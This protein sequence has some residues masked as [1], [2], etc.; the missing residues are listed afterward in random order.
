MARKCAQASMPGCPRVD[1]EIGRHAAVPREPR[2]ARPN[3][4]VATCL[5]KVLPPAPGE[6]GGCRFRDLT[7]QVAAFTT[8]ARLALADVTRRLPCCARSPLPFPPSSGPPGAWRCCCSLDV[9]RTVASL[10]TRAPAA[11]RRQVE[12][13]QRAGPSGRAGRTPP[14]A[15][16]GP[17]GGPEQA[18]RQLVGR[19][20][21]AARPVLAGRQRR[22]ARR[23]RAEQ[24]GVA[25]PLPPAERRAR[26]ARPRAAV[27]PRPGAPRRRAA[28]RE[29]AGRAPV[30]PP[31]P[32]ARATATCRPSRP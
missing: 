32:A 1:H 28:R 10:A 8:G 16:P 5:A 31:A 29:R 21:K 6:F 27:Q 23:E 2:A 20:P 22:V 15:R 11:R 4:P 24:P 26:A 25:A 12:R 13:R 7:E 14:A 18:G 30:A 9:P 17:A 19:L 3:T